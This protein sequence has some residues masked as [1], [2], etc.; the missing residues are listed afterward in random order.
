MRRIPTTELPVIPRVIRR[1]PY[2]DTTAGR[3]SRPT[4]HTACGTLAIGVAALFLAA[5]E[6]ADSPTEPPPISASAVVSRSTIT[7]Y[8][9]NGPLFIACAN[10]GLGEDMIFEGTVIT[11]TSVTESAGGTVKVK[12]RSDAE[13][14]FR[15]IGLTTGDVYYTAT[16]G[17]DGI[18]RGVF[19]FTQVLNKGGGQATVVQVEDY[20]NP[21]NGDH[22]RTRRKFHITLNA[23]GD[24]TVLFDQPWC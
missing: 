15:A 6:A 11:T 23:Q 5:C 16:R 1:T 2:H 8:V 20:V 18:A 7:E 22:I 17:P 4:R 13:A 21:V 19:E 24:V 10:G 12:V 14:D 9:Q 3:Q